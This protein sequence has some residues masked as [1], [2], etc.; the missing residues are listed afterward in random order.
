MGSLQDALLQSGLAENKPRRDKADPR[1]GKPARPDGGRS[2]RKGRKPGG[3][4]PG[5][6]P[7]RS[8]GK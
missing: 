4:A 5:S 3:K 2:G 8:S 7:A 1:P 6:A